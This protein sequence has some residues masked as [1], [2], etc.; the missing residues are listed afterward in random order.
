MKIVCVLITGLFLSGCTMLGGFTDAILFNN[1]GSLFQH[2]GNKV[3]KKIIKKLSK[4]KDN[5]AP[6]RATKRNCRYKTITL[7]Q[8]FTKLHELKE[9]E[10]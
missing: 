2:L 6:K 1:K 8:C 4:K 10:K 9:Q 5:Y 7:D 3:D